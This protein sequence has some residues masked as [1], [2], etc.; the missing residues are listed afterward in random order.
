MCTN[1]SG[2]YGYGY[3]C[4]WPC[5]CWGYGAG[6]WPWG[7]GS[8]GCWGSS[9]GC[10]STGTGCGESASD[11]CGQTTSSCCDDTTTASSTS[12]V[13]RVL[14]VN[15]GWLLVCDQSTCQQVRVNTPCA[16][17][18]RVGE[19]LRICYDG[20]MTASIPPQISASKICRI[21]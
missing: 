19:R 3:R 4:C 10:G 2:C 17:C 15:D 12:L 21:C 14:E 7:W 11:C 9:S 1:Y 6:C 13:G 8:S 20:V 18:Y 16:S 5:C